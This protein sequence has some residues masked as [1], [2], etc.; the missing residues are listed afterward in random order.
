M[1][2]KRGDDP[3]TKIL[4]IVDAEELGSM[5]DLLKKEKKEN[6]SNT[7]DIKSEGK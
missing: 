7:S 6:K 4:R 2:I 3:K 5:E 1:F